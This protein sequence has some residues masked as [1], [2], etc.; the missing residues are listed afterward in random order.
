MTEGL[1]K[2]PGGN[3]KSVHPRSK[4]TKCSNRGVLSQKIGLKKKRKKTDRAE[5]SLRVCGFRTGAYQVLHVVSNITREDVLLYWISSQ[6]HCGHGHEA[7]G[8]A[9]K[10]ITLWQYSAL[11]H[12]LQCDT[13]FVQR[14]GKLYFGPLTVIK[15][16]LWFV[17]VFL[18]YLFA[19]ANT[20]RSATAPGWR[21]LV[22]RQ[23]GKHSIYPFYF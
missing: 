6:V 21:L 5:A 15:N 18:N 2:C 4:R 9:P 17:C 20:N 8:P 10:I 14:L 7:A 11:Q 13:A 12:V 16:T 3:I 1:R 22:F 19:A 23:P